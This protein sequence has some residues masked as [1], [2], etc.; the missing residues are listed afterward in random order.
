MIHRTPCITDLDITLTNRGNVGKMRVVYV[1]VWF[2]P[3]GCIYTI[4]LVTANMFYTPQGVEH[5]VG[6]TLCTLSIVYTE[7]TE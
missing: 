2:M 7:S 6:A 3:N 4:F 5:K 1:L